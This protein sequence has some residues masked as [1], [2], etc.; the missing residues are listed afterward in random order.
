MQS[1]AVGRPM[2]ILL[3]ED[4]L[5]SAKLTIGV[6]QNS[7]V[8][9]RMT[10]LTDGSDAVEFLQQKGKYRQAPQPDLVLLD[11]QLPGQDGESVLRVVRADDRLQR[12]P[13]IV[14]TGSATEAVMRD[15]RAL[16]VQGFLHKPINIEEFLRLV[17]ELRQFWRE[18]MIVPAALS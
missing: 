4:S 5:A 6:L 17:Q 16:E 12:V 11:L 14:L 7:Q 8:M 15:V 2:E 9:H 3:V 18:D 1:D 13:V 10:W